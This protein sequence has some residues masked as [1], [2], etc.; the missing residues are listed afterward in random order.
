MRVSRLTND[1]R[2]P[3]QA[4]ILA[5]VLL[6]A[7]LAFV[8][9]VFKPWHDEGVVERVPFWAAVVVVAFPASWWAVL[10]RTAVTTGVSFLGLGGRQ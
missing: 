2:T 1:T 3:P 7:G 5:A 6:A 10:D 8:L 4:R 9:W